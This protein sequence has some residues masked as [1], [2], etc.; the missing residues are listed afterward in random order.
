MKVLGSAIPT[1][2]G[3]FLIEEGNSCEFYLFIYLFIPNLLP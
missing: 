2:V 1:V 3:T